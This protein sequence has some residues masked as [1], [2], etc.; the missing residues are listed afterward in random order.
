MPKVRREG[1]SSSLRVV[2]SDSDDGS[3]SQSGVWRHAG[4]SYKRPMTRGRG[5]LPLLCLLFAAAKV[6]T[7]CGADDDGG[8]GGSVG[9]VGPPLRE[10]EYATR[11]SFVDA[12]AKRTCT[13]QA[14]CCGEHGQLVDPSCENDHRER[15]APPDTVTYSPSGG[16]SCLAAVTAAPCEDGPPQLGRSGCTDVYLTSNQGTT[17]LPCRRPSRSADF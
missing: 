12:F 8:G 10:D 1:R 6:L 14:R 2:A 13:A 4:L 16:A 17:P 5:Y 7:S 9:F 15:E 3:R 11:S